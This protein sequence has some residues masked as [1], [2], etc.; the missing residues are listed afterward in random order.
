MLRTI[1]L[2]GL[3][4]ALTTGA[5]LAQSPSGYGTEGPYGKRLHARAQSTFDR[6]WNAANESKHR[7]E[8]SARWVR[9]HGQGLPNP[10]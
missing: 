2:T 5:A 1:T 7:A 9:Q 3:A 8:S 6:H 10:F 4:M